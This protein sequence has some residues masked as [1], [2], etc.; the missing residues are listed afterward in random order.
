[1]YG[2]HNNKYM[3]IVMNIEK[4]FK[5]NPNDTERY[6]HKYGL[7]SM[8]TAYSFPNYS[9]SCVSN[10]RFVSGNTFYELICGLYNRDPKENEKEFFNFVMSEIFGCEADRFLEKV[11]EH[12]HRPIF[13]NYYEAWARLLVKYLYEADAVS[14][15]RYLHFD[16]RSA[17]TE[18]FFFRGNS[19]ESILKSFKFHFKRTHHL[20][21]LMKNN[22]NDWVFR[23]YQYCIDFNAMP[24][25]RYSFDKRTFINKCP[26]IEYSFQGK[27]FRKSNYYNRRELIV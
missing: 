24:A 26:F 17:R 6:G 3:E 18:P 20:K 14:P 12:S 21:H 15:Y 23:F 25:D 19:I 10:C 4:E 9:S 8:N 11:D 22:V 2:I 16:L 1:M 27:A 7:Y 13:E 5:I